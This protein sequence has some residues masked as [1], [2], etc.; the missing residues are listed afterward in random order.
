M[1]TGVLQRTG[2]PGGCVA[3]RG[4]WIGIKLI[5]LPNAEQGSA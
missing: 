1:H 5:G 2:V 4:H 3:I